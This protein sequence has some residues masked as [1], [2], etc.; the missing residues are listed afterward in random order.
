[1]SPSLL[2]CQ[3]Y[4]MPLFWLQLMD[5]WRRG[6]TLDTNDR[7]QRLRRILFWF[8]VQDMPRRGYT[9][10]CVLLN[11]SSIHKGSDEVHKMVADRGDM[12]NRCIRRCV[13]RLM[14]SRHVCLLF[15]VHTKKNSLQQEAAFSE[16]Y[17]LIALYFSRYFLPRFYIK[18]IVFTGKRVTKARLHLLSCSPSLPQVKLICNKINEWETV[19]HLKV[20]QWVTLTFFSPRRIV[21]GF[22]FVRVEWSSKYNLE[23]QVFAFASMREVLYII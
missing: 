15:G 18:F 1:M 20:S 2:P 23:S 12:W 22:F 5:G 16:M 11:S 3:S 8:L 21:S 14:S 4:G 6:L 9:H 10:L 13:Y 19:W 17:I 7:C